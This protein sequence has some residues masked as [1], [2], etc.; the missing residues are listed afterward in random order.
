MLMFDEYDMFEDLFATINV[1]PKFGEAMFNEDDLFS[2]PPLIDQTY[3]DD[4]MAPIYDD[5][6]YESGFGEAMSL[7]SDTSTIL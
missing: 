1:C 4:S 5:Y 2:P 7:F 3:F 6:N